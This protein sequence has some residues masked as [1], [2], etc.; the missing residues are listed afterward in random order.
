MREIDIVEEFKNRLVNQ[1]GYNESDIK[2][3]E[4]LKVYSK[5]IIRPDILVY[6]DNKPHILIEVKRLYINKEFD[7][8]FINNI[9]IYAKSIGVNYFAIVTPEVTKAFKIDK[10]EVISIPDIPSK[11]HKIINHIKDYKTEELIHVF[12]EM[13]DIIWSGGKRVDYEIINQF[14]KLL[15]LKYYMEENSIFF[16]DN[17]KYL[18]FEKFQSLYMEANNEYQIFETNSRLEYNEKEF[19]NLIDL[20]KNINLKSISNIEEIYFTSFIRPLK[21]ELVLSN[22]VIYLFQ[23]VQ[24]ISNNIVIINSGFGQLS[25]KFN[26]I[27]NI[28]SNVIKIRTLKILSLIKDLNQES[29]LDEVLYSERRLKYDTIIATPPLRL[30]V[31]EYDEYEIESGKREKDY[32]SLVIEKSNHLLAPKGYLFILLPNSVLSNI[33]FRNTR[34]YIQNNFNI[35]SII[36]LENIAY[37]NTNV[38][39][40]LLI[41][42]KKEEFYQKQESSVLF[43]DFKKDMGE[44]QSINIEKI[45]NQKYKNLDENLI[46]IDDLKDRWDYHYYLNDFMKLEKRINSL[47]LYK[48]KEHFKVVRG[49]SLGHDNIGT[50]PLITVSSIENGKIIEEKLS[51]I[52]VE[53]NYKNERGIVQENDLLLTVVGKYSKCALVTK[54]FE[55]ANTNSG[56]VIL[57]AY[58]SNIDIN[59]LYKYLNSPVGQALLYRGVTYT[60]TVPILTQTEIMEILVVLEEYDQLLD[61]LP[62]LKDMFSENLV[63]QRIDKECEEKIKNELDKYKKE[64]EDSF[65]EKSDE[66]K[67]KFILSDDEE[68][69]FSVFGLNGN[70]FSIEVV[71]TFVKLKDLENFETDKQSFQRELNITHNKDLVEFLKE[72]KYKFFPEIV[73]G[74]KNIDD[75]KREGSL[76][77]ETIEVNSGIS[78]L[79]F[80]SKKVFNNI[81]VL[82]GRHRIESIKEYIKDDSINKDDTVSI[83]FILLNEQQTNDLLDKAIFYNLNAKARVL[84]EVDYLNLLANDEDDKLSELNITNINI[85]KFLEDNIDK[86]FRDNN[87]RI[88]LTKCI[89]LTNYIIENFD[90]RTSE[91]YKDKILELLEETNQNMLNKFDI[92]TKTKFYQLIIFIIANKIHIN[93]DK[94]KQFIKK[95]LSGFIEWLTLSNLIKSLD[96]I[97]NFKNLYLNYEKTYIPKSRKIYLSMPYHK[98]TEWTYFLVKDVVNNVE[99]KLNINIELIRTDEKTHGVHKGISEVVYQ[100]IQECDLMIADLSGDNP[101]VFNEVGFKMG[102]DKTL[103]LKETQVIFIINT[104]S[105]YDEYIEKGTILDDGFNI[106]GK[107]IKNKTKPV[108][109]NL[110]GIK[111]IDFYDSKYLK[112][113]LTNELM[114]YFAYYKIYKKNK[115]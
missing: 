111:H 55:G 6:K 110:R 74:I 86:L 4:S 2:T 52:T 71:R 20:I 51:K 60:S 10:N 39:T 56:I 41:L 93:N 24:S 104:K 38:L 19:Y 100:Q 85:F 102:I 92:N 33:S 66:F 112:T 21:N 18:Y 67:N 82:D 49:S 7:D 108:P 16:N 84:E 11:N 12:R 90:E 101:N 43:L 45:F 8:T 68:N 80:K 34:E 17:E 54:E 13:R 22:S 69:E 78:K 103:G 42:Q 37:E 23:G 81:E 105:Y 31:R 107:I 14:N 5:T 73:L 106:E 26:D 35:M 28:E 44:G 96:E 109:F 62:I 65:K 30:K 114:E 83:V 88:V 15:L 95:E 79:I 32:A 46:L 25:L 50:I 59:Y 113:E 48:I 75:L 98:E 70:V 3:D 61:E 76:I 63:T 97:D 89:V 57:R 53:A 29:I 40:S 47:K 72:G 1:Y 94:V 27:E 87:R 77:H 36:S 99:K 91:S 58:S 9:S 115:I 64:F